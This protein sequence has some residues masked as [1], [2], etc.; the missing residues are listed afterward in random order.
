MSASSGRRLVAA[1]LLLGAA[2]LFAGCSG[3]GDSP[4]PAASSSSA[5][6][7]LATTAVLGN[8]VGRVPRSDAEQAMHQVTK[9]TDGWI[10]AAYVGGDYPRSDFGEAFPGFTPGAAARAVRDRRLMSNAAI[11]ARVDE[12]TAR[13]RRVRVDLLAVDKH[14]K[15]ATAHVRLVFTTGGDVQRRGTVTGRLLLTATKDGWQVFA[16]DIAR[17]DS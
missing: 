17:G 16:Y 15:A 2:P 13:V 3:G 6:P 8:V 9:V 12:V 10:D 14:V 11:G 7:P 1:A 4:A 5:P